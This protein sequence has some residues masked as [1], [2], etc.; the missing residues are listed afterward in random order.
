MV[1]MD[2]E[3]MS[4]SLGNMVFVRD[5]LRKYS[6]DALRL[7]LLSH[8]Y[9]SVFEWSPGDLEA[10]A[11]VADRLT[12]AAAQP[13][14]RAASDGGRFGA[15]LEDDLN[16]RGRSSRSNAPRATRCAAWAPVLGRT[17]HARDLQRADA[18]RESRH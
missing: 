2:G 4:K 15:A 16:T 13:D 6:V 12:L 1:R 18:R 14:D 10:A 3:K 9:R 5:L 8:H 17:V 11:S 7:Y